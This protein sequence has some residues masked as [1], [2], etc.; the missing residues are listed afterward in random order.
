V[1]ILI[2]FA[3]PLTTGGDHFGGLDFIKAYYAVCIWNCND[4]LVV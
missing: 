3:L 1:I 4:C 2:G